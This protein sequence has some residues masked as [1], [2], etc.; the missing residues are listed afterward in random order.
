DYLS[1][2][3]GGGY[4]AGWLQAWIHR[5]QQDPGTA[6]EVFQ[7]LGGRP[8]RPVSPLAPEPKPLDHLRQFSNYL[9]PRLGLF[10]ADTWTAAA[11]FVRNLLLNWLVILPLLAALV[12]IPQGVYLVVQSTV[13]PG[14]G[15]NLLY[16]SVIV[17]L[18]ASFSIYYH[19]RFVRDPD[20]PS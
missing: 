14:L 19:R 2:V 7:D 16:A 12:V 11:I 15:T 20:T 9:T 6:R 13:S 4:I 18:L 17:E 1:S 8:E 10:S 3:S 5:Q